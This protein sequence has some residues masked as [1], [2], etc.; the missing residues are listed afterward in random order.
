M[1]QVT[2]VDDSSGPTEPLASVWEALG[3]APVSELHAGHQSRVFLASGRSGPRIVKL[4]ETGHGDAFTRKRVEVA[5][6]LAEI[7]PTV[8]G[9]IMLESGLVTEIER[10]QVVCYPY[11]EGTPPDTARR[12]D[13]E[14]MAATLASLHRSMAALAHVDLPPVMALRG[15]TGHRMVHE[16]IIHGDYAS[17]NLINTPTGLRIIDF[18]DCGFGSVEFDVGNSLYMARFDAWHG[19]SPGRYDRF[20][21]WFVD[22]YHIAASTDFDA[23]VVDEAIQVRVNALGRWLA[24]PDQAP[25][26]IRTASPA[27]RAK[28]RSFVEHATPGGDEVGGSGRVGLP[29]S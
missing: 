7:N 26:G 6:E 19:G 5:A 16:Q 2:R 21:S 15:Q 23:A 25:T 13:V 20:R 22:A 17:A 10:W 3:L 18:A 4:I 8:V 24:D 28:L 29:R 27:W 14:A 1:D 9:P 12:A 11:V